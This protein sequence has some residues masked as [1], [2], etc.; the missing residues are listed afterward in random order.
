M[1]QKMEDSK[2]CFAQTFETKRANEA[3]GEL[4]NAGL[5]AKLDAYI[6]ALAITTGASF[7][8]PRALNDARHL[9]VIWPVN[10]KLWLQ[11]LLYV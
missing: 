8:E 2:R 1:S 6:Y 7:P 3:R 9:S 11:F 4:M 10:V 5:G